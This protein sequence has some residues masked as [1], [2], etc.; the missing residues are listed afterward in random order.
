MNR[1]PYTVPIHCA[2]QGCEAKAD[3]TIHEE[4][5][6]PGAKVTTRTHA[7]SGWTESKGEWY[8]ALHQSLAKA[9]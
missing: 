5:E 9:Q 8:C 1:A 4:R 2:K 6:G 3:L 7:P